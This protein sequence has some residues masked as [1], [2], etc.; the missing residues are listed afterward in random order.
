MPANHAGNKHPAEAAQANTQNRHLLFLDANVLTS[1]IIMQWLIWLR[2]TSPS[3]TNPTGTNPSGT[4]PTQT[5]ALCTSAKV[6][7]ETNNTLKYHA[8]RDFEQRQ[9]HMK[10][11]RDNLNEQIEHYP[12]GVPFSGKDPNDYHVHAAATA[13]ADTALTDTKQLDTPTPHPVTLLTF[14][15]PSDFTKRA[16]TECYS[17][18]TPDDFLFELIEAG[19]QAHTPPPELNLDT[20]T[21]PP[22]SSL[23]AHIRLLK[24]AKCPR[25]AK[26]IAR[27]NSQSS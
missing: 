8:G 26:V 23:E 21:S 18:Q 19:H 3:D 12:E 27:L 15:R 6:L 13:L 4:N 9:L 16:A 20:E 5:L 11:L 24:R 7:S 14:N 25:F 10:W 2:D 17:I 22:T 1:T